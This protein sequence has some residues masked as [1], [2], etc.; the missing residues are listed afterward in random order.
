MKRLSFINFALIISRVGLAEIFQWVSTWDFALHSW[1][2]ACH[3]M[4]QVHHPLA[5]ERHRTIQFSYQQGWANPLFWMCKKL[6]YSRNVFRS[7][8]AYVWVSPRPRKVTL[9]LEVVLFVFW[10]ESTNSLQKCFSYRCFQ[11]MKTEPTAFIWLRLANSNV[12]TQSY[13][14]G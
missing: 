4:C 1:P 10:V 12:K 9:L 8:T 11:G 5:A 7:K 14:S 6:S 2:F 13:E 3:Q